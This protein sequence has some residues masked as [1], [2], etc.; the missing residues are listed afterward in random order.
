MQ[1][2]FAKKFESLNALLGVQMLAVNKLNALM[3]EELIKDEFYFYKENYSIA[4]VYQNEVQN[5]R[6]Y[7][8]KRLKDDPEYLKK[9]YIQAIALFGD[10][11][12]N[13][14]RFINE[15]ESMSDVE[16]IKLWLRDFCEYASNITPIGYLAEMFGGYDNYWSDYIGI[17]Q[18][19]F[20]ILTSPDELSFSKQYEYELSKLKLSDKTFGVAE[21]A[22]K[23]YWVRNNYFI[24]D[25]LDENYI[26]AQLEKISVD[27]ARETTSERESVI[28]NI[29]NKKKEILKRLSIENNRLAILDGL[30][31]FVVL[32]DRR[33]EVVLKTNSFLVRAYKKLLDIYAYNESDRRVVLSAAPYR[34][35]YELTKEELLKKS[36]IAFKGAYSPVSGEIIIGVDAVKMNEQLVDEGKARNSEKIKGQVAYRGKLSGRVRVVLRNTDF[37][38]FQDGDILVASMTR[39]EFVSLMKMASAFITDEGGI[40]CHAAIVAREMKKPCI[41]GTKIAT[42]VLH[43]GDLVEVDAER[44]IVKILK[45]AESCSFRKGGADSGIVKVLEKNNAIENKLTEEDKNLADEYITLLNGRKLYPPLNN[46]SAFIQGSEYNTERYAKKWWKENVRPDML[47]SMQTGKWQVLLPNDDFIVAVKQTFQEYVAKQ[48]IFT[49]RMKIL[50]RNIS[51]IDKIYKEH[52]YAFI[53]KAIWKELLQIITKTRDLIWDANA[54]VWF[55]I[56][57]DKEFGWS[58]VNEMNIRISRK[59]F[60]YVWEYATHPFF[61]SFDKQQTDE[62]LA[63]LKKKTS[64]Q[65]LIEQC[66]YFATDYHSAKTLKEIENEL[67]KRYVGAFKDLGR[68]LK[69]NKIEAAR[70]KLKQKQYQNWLKGLS[71]EECLLANFL[72]LIMETRDKRKNFFAKGLTIIYRIA[73]KMFSEAEIDRELI[74]YYT[75]RE[76]LQGTKYLISKSNEL[77]QRPKGFQLL[78]PY[79]GE[80]TMLLRPIETTLRKIQDYYFDENISQNK[81]II[82]GQS[83]SKGKVRGRARIVLNVNSKHGFQKGEILVTGMTRP[84]YVPLMKQAA[85]I[86]TDEGGITCHAAI[87]SR[88]L[89]I[90]C[91]IGTKFATHILKDGDLVEVD[92]ERGIVKILK[93][94]DANNNGKNVS[95]SKNKAESRFFRKSRVDKGAVRII[96]KK[97]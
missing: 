32:Q 13:E 90:P 56:Y 10:F 67:K 95:Q 34:W 33:K 64:W 68:A 79:S 52:S 23:W 48:S 12:K 59:R 41:I 89:G 26:L 82:S 70:F 93:K 78:I 43:D 11:R 36:R 92:A 73:E 54:A 30:A 77:Q 17:S 7:C 5:V 75:M 15:I 74:P 21:L 14:A 8:L 16:K 24:V 72:Q 2:K 39:P 40:T 44:G 28:L 76:L 83:G 20:T 38:K 45:K 29:K 62:F 46:Y 4:Y 96:E 18:E 47:I 31:N 61:E 6:N 85:G 37:S 53:E 42:Q 57:I 87:V 71:K 60:D 94:A 25:L 19:D 9:L 58:F 84:E 66:Q 97:K 51:L 86:V 80:M 91:V 81:N 65:K 1:E 63:L 55:C 35:F 88:E 49:R 27:E 3:G 22:K 50:D 69:Q